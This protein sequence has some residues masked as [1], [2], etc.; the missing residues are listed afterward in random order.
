MVTLQD[1][2]SVFISPVALEG[3]VKIVQQ[4]PIAPTNFAK[5]LIVF[6]ATHHNLIT[7]LSMAAYM[8]VVG[9]PSTPAEEY[10]CGK[11]VKSHVGKCVQIEDLWET[12]E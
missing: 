4:Q 5:A 6:K 3:T 8:I 7:A 10:V 11:I 2:A 1:T 9:L 12:I